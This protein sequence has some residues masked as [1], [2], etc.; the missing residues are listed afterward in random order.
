MA[1]GISFT[2]SDLRVL[3]NDQELTL[4]VYEGGAFV[5]DWKSSVEIDKNGVLKIISPSDMGIMIFDNPDKSGTSVSVSNGDSVNI[6][7]NDYPDGMYISMYDA[8]PVGEYTY[9]LNITGFA[10]EKITQLKPFLQSIANA[11]R[12]KKG[13]TETIN[14]QNFASEIENIESS[15][16]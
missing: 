7:I 13:T 10:A 11:I 5:S 8:P 12:T 4:E 9:T 6:D 14:A 1:I 15:G 2:A 3:L 16:G